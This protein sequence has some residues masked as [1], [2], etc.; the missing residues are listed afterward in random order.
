MSPGDVGELA[1][2]ISSSRAR[3]LFRNKR[4]PN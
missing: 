4:Q 3:G 2:D 1:T